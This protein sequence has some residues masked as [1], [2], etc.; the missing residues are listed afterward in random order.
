MTSLTPRPSQPSTASPAGTSGSSSGSSPRS[1]ACWRST[2]Y[3]SSA[4]KSSRPR[5]NHGSSAR[6]DQRQIA[7]EFLR[8]EALKI[9]YTFLQDGG[10]A[11]AEKYGFSAA[12]GP[13]TRN[14]KIG[15]ASRRER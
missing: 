1:P 3:A 13:A 8:H 7:L 5:E 2:D 15:R 6:S 11:I 14:G 4:G 9:T 12:T 10:R